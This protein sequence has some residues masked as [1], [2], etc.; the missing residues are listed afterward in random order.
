MFV[1]EGWGCSLRLAFS[2]AHAREVG[3]VKEILVRLLP[4]IAQ[5]A[6]SQ[7]LIKD[8]SARGFA[9]FADP[10]LGLDSV[11]AL[12]SE[13]ERVLHGKSGGPYDSQTIPTKVRF[14]TSSAFSLFLNIH[15]CVAGA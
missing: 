4:M 2:A 10:A 11:T 15:W 8:F 6:L 12:R 5:L 1:G 9:I 3:V 7:T 14:L 13:L